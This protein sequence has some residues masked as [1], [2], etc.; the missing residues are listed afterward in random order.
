MW[1]SITDTR[2][3]WKLFLSFVFS[4]DHYK[5]LQEGLFLSVASGIFWTT[6]RRHW[7][8]LGRTGDPGCQYPR[9]T[10]M[11]QPSC[12]CAQMHKHTHT[13]THTHTLAAPVPGNHLSGGW[14]IYCSLTSSSDFP[15]IRMLQSFLIHK[16]E[17]PLINSKFFAFITRSFTESVQMCPEKNGKNRNVCPLG[18][19]CLLTKMHA[20]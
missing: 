17:F 3:K 2:W 4:P 20:R 9:A 8:L 10:R 15:V 11:G 12:T 16:G 6:R 1:L 7:L 13:H 14:W 5:R 18:L 19:N